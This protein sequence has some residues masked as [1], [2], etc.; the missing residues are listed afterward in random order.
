MAMTCRLLIY[1]VK[2]KETSF[3]LTYSI[4]CESFCVI[5][6]V[7]TNVLLSPKDMLLYSFHNYSFSTV[8]VICINVWVKE[9]TSFVYVSCLFCDTDRH[10]ESGATCSINKCHSS[11]VFLAFLRSL[12]VVVWDVAWIHGPQSLAKQSEEIESDK[13]RKDKYWI[14]SFNPKGGIIEDID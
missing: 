7:I 9:K 3:W 12:S 1:Y 10:W 2:V 11:Y 6:T 14:N 4:N 13:N 5:Q 8:I